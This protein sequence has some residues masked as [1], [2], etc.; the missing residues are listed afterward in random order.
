MVGRLLSF[1]HAP[2]FWGHVSFSGVSVSDCKMSIPTMDSGSFPIFQGWSGSFWDV[3]LPKAACSTNGWYT[4]L[5]HET[6]LEGATI[7]RWTF[8]MPGMKIKIQ[9]F[10]RQ[11]S[12]ST[13]SAPRNPKKLDVVLLFFKILVLEHDRLLV[14]LVNNSQKIQTFWGI[15]LWLETGYFHDG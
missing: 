1:K 6:N 14:R 8:F 10:F 5:S 12:M 7:F 15:H 11:K 4:W 3:I 2:P 9:V 13:I